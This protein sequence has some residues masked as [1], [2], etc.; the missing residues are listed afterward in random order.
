MRRAVIL[1]LATIFCGLTVSYAQTQQQQVVVKT[2]GRLT[3]ERAECQPVVQ[4]IV[5]PKGASS[6]VYSDSRGCA[7]FGVPATDGYYISSVYK[8]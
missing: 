1:L 5:T 8:E 6:G 2:R 3:T 4:A 7:R